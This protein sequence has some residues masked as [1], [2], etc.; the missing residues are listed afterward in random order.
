MGSFLSI[1]PYKS[2]VGDAPA[3]VSASSIHL[4]ALRGAA[5]LVVFAGHARGLFFTTLST[6]SSALS[7]SPSGDPVV[8]ATWGHQAV[9]VFFVLSGYLVGGSVLRG[10][11]CHRWSW[12]TYAVR[13]LSRLWVVLLPALLLG[14]A[15]DTFGRAHFASHGALYDP[16]AHVSPILPGLDLRLGWLPLLGNA[17]FLQGIITPILGTNQPLWSLTYE[18]WYY[19]L[20]PVGALV[21]L[22]ESTAARRLGCAFLFVLAGLFIGPVILTYFLVWLMG[23]VVYLLPPVIPNNQRRVA[24]AGA[25]VLY[26]ISAIV[27]RRALV[28]PGACLALL[29]FSISFLLYCLLH[30]RQPASNGI[31]SSAARFSSNISYTLYLTHAPALTLLC[32]VLLQ[33][34]HPWPK[35]TAHLGAFCVVLLV[36]AAYSTMVY[37]CFEAHTAR[38]R[39]WLKRILQRRSL[40]ALVSDRS[41]P[42]PL[43]R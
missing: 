26:F 15:M 39:E 35:D 24:T 3:S 43:G 25:L 42:Q 13:R 16:Q 7:R 28:P 17:F 18:F 9:L 19:L 36:V 37:F 8:F 33:P 11:S 5:A 23:V 31:Y 41:A 2:D 6:A 22:R 12:T 10:L 38:V 4:D 27:A 14:L 20:F 29:T 21:F 32:A 40:G 34:W 1:A 30:A